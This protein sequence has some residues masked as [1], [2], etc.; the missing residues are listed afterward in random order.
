MQKGKRPIDVKPQA[1]LVFTKQIKG[2]FATGPG[3]EEGFHYDNGVAVVAN[4]DHIVAA[5]RNLQT[6]GGTVTAIEALGNRNAEATPGV[7][8]HVISNEPALYVRCP[9]KK[10]GEMVPQ[11]EYQQHYASH[12]RNK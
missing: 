12:G 10:C 9:V 5:Q 4:Q 6:P 1:Y 2:F 8:M 3:V 11:A 7:G